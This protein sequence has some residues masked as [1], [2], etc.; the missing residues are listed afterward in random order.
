MFTK[1]R[2]Y[3]IPIFEGMC[4]KEIEWMDRKIDK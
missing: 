2:F 4:V 3:L 1:L